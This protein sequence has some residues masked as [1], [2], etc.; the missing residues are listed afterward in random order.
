LNL[1]PNTKLYFVT[2]P[3]HIAAAIEV[4]NKI[5]VLDQ[6]LPIQKITTWVK[7]QLYRCDSLE[8]YAIY[9]IIRKENG[10]DLQKEKIE[11]YI[12]KNLLNEEYTKPNWDNIV[13]EI[14]TA[15][16]DKKPNFEFKLK[17][18]AIWYDINDAIIKESLYRCIKNILRKE[19][20]GN[21]SKIKNIELKQKG[22]DI[23]VHL[24]FEWG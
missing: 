21:Y 18:C 22:N 19:F 9:K 2:R 4:N 11:K 12:D 14:Y 17:N 1:F 13:E 20:C 3:K 10:F 24:Q 7:I 5:Y 23:V 6:R 8:K 15:I 16:D